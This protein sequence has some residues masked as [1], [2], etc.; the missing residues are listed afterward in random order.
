MA[1]AIKL[2]RRYIEVLRQERDILKKARLK[3]A[4]VFLPK[5]VRAARH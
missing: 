5:R 4:R 1:A 3:K 2:L